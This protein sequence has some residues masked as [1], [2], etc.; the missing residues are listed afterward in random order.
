M[1]EVVAPADLPGGYTFDAEINGNIFKV[2]VPPGGVKQGQ[3]FSVP[4]PTT[5]TTTTTRVFTEDAPMGAW[6]DGL[7]D[8]FKHGCCHPH[9][10]LALWCQPIAAAQVM[11]RMSL[12]WIADAA[13]NKSRTFATVCKIVIAYYVVDQLI[14]TLIIQMYR[15]D[16]QPS[17]SGNQYEGAKI[18][19]SIRE[20]LELAFWAYILVITCKTRK[21]VREKY[22]IPEKNCDGCEDVCCSFWCGPCTVAQMARH[23]TDYRSND[24][25]CCVET[26]YRRPN[27]NI[28]QTV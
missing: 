18:A 8:F 27:P 25:S 3:R 14:K 23:T 2:V 15:S 7:F 13:N 26:G 5:K 10:C 1:V 12:N 19:G 6:R 4:A 20:A 22:E 24:A 28:I 21:S 11:T 16:T 17:Y 9:L